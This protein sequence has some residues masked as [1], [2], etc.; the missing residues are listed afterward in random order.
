MN[1]TAQPLDALIDPAGGDSLLQ[2][3]RETVA[4][5]TKRF[6][7]AYWLKCAREGRFIDEQWKAMGELGLLGLSVPE[8]YGG[9][10][11][12]VMGMVL[13]KDLL[14]RA[15]IPPLM[16]TVTGLARIPI[17]KYGTKAQIEK[18]VTPTVSGDLKICFALTEP[19]AG[20][21][22]FKITTH[23][24]HENGGWVLNGQKTF[25][26][27]VSDADV[28]M[29]VARTRPY[30]EGASRKDGIS[31]FML[32]LKTPGIEYHPLNIDLKIPEKQFTV[33]F[34]DV[35]LP[36]DALIGEEGRGMGLLFDA[37]NPERLLTAASAVGIGDYAIGRTVEY[38]K[39]RAPFG[40][41][42]G[43]YQA[44]QHPLARAKAK[45]ESARI[46]MYQTA[47]YFDMG[48][49]AGPASNMVK[50]LASEAAVEA[51]DAAIQFHGGNGFDIDYDI[52]TLWPLARLTRVAPVN[53]EMMLN[54]IGEHVL[55][56]PKSY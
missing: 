10:G 22:S 50:F 27:A 9:S 2:G 13:V 54:Y 24:S 20:T 16:L 19:E 30:S 17:I 29:V 11:G 43:S 15:G 46:M 55:G 48:G 47:R 7:R 21:N 5:L 52:I 6:D 31:V 35:K 37:L 42:L 38:V 41:P 36:E 23:A 26:S 33:F 18:W 32:D 44:V 8:E 53:N 45:I 39:Q 12:G 4:G 14:S 56:L 28:M 34:D 3:V 40:A 51:V 25:I 1:L 49:R